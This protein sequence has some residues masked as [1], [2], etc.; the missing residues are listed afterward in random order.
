LLGDFFSETGLLGGEGNVNALDLVL[1]I[2][3]NIK[4]LQIYI[5]FVYFLLNY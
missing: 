1:Y 4:F 5:F 2:W 3:I